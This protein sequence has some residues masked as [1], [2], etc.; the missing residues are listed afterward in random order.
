MLMSVFSQAD[1]TGM[2]PELAGARVLVTG[3]SPAAGVDLVRAFADH[4]ARLVLQTDDE[5]PEITELA[6]IL[7]Q[8]ASEIRLYASP[9]GPGEAAVRFAQSAAQA[10]GGPDV[11]V[12]L[13]SITAA[14][15]AGL[16]T[17]AEIETFVMTKLGAALEMTRVL[18]NRMRLTLGTGLVLNVVIA[19]APRSAAEAALIGIV[20]A[21]LAAMTR[22]EAEA[23]AG[24]DIRINAIGP[25]AALPGD[26]PSGACLTSEPDIAALALHLAS[27]KGRQLSGHVFD[28]ERVAARGC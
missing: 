13:V 9:I 23:W 6:A 7:A 12:N 16:S 11:A 20:R 25:R 4:K 5:T 2:H 17:E 15:L 19:P 22:A 28:A 26:P 18:A 21:A 8:S 14:D 10:F 27:K 24:Q 3:L 1:A